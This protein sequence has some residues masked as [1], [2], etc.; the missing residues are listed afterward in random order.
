M[1]CFCLRIA[2]LF[3]EDSEDIQSTFFMEDGAP[4]HTS[5]LALDWLEM[6]FP[7]GL[8]SNKSDFICGPHVLL[9]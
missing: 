5:R 1:A 3:P 4:A 8:I 9:T 7:E 6:T 2:E